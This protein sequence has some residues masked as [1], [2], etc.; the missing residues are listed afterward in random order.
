MPQQRALSEISPMSA[1]GL[2]RWFWIAVREYIKYLLHFARRG[3]LAEMLTVS[4]S[5]QLDL[6][7]RTY[8]RGQEL[9]RDRHGLSGCLGINKRAI[10]PQASSP[11]IKAT[12]WWS[13][14]SRR[15]GSSDIDQ[16]EIDGLTV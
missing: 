3:S 10:A 7:K 14:C 11:L 4:K 15:F 1:A 16:N 8:H 2:L 6:D 9:R 12:A 5:R 13:V